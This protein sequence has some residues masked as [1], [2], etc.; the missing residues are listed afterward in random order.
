LPRP[1]QRHQ[2]RICLLE[3]AKDKSSRSERP[4]HES[5]RSKEGIGAVYYSQPSVEH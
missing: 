2:R 4:G 3:R 5:D 1:I